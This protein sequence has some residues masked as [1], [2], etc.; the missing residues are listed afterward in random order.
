M[1]AILVM[2]VDG[3]SNIQEPKEEPTL[4][5]DASTPQPPSSQ[6]LAACILSVKSE[7]TIKQKVDAVKEAALSESQKVFFLSSTY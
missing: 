3:I 2:A 4:D 1:A 6:S 7:D 5:G